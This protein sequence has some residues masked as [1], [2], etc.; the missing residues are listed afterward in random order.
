MNPY[1]KSNR[2]TKLKENICDSKSI[3]T[4]PMTEMTTNRLH[5]PIPGD[6]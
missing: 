3:L 2:K 6:Y 4:M 1:E 5:D